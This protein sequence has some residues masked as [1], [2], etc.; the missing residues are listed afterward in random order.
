MPG[1]PEDL[2][3]ETVDFVAN[4]DNTLQEPLV[5][6]ARFPVLLV[7]G[8]QGIAVGM[9]TNIPPHNL[10]ETI[11]AT[12]HL[13]HHPDTSITELMQYVPAPDFPTGG[14]ILGRRGGHRRIHHRAWLSAHAGKTEIEDAGKG[15]SENRGNRIPYLVNKARMVD[16]S[17]N[18]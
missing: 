15:L 12:I 11:D 16:T 5:L 13:I 7:I 10:G 4:Y 1:S 9:A 14:F 2:D 8:S 3:K 6:P 17:L 18:S